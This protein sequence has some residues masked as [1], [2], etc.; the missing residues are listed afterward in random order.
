MEENAQKSVSR[1][2]LMKKFGQH[3]TTIDAFGIAVQMQIHMYTNKQRL[4]YALKFS[5]PYNLYD[6]ES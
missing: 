5:K 3:L 1:S 4:S 6:Q 2:T